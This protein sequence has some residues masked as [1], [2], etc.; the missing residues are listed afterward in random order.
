[1][2]HHTASCGILGACR[3]SS[4]SGAENPLRLALSGFLFVWELAENH[5]LSNWC[6]IMSS[7]LQIG[8]ENH[9]QVNDR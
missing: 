7:A 1:M 3:H 8:S 4:S 2:A 9:S 6:S 5:P